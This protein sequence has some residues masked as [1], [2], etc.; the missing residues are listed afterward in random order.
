[1]IKEAVKR[2]CSLSNWE[3]KGLATAIFVNK[4][5]SCKSFR[6]KFPIE[7]GWLHKYI[8]SYKVMPHPIPFLL[9]VSNKNQFRYFHLHGVSVERRYFIKR[10]FKKSMQNFIER[11]MPDACLTPYCSDTSYNGVCKTLISCF[12]A[13]FT[14]SLAEVSLLSLC[15]YSLTLVMFL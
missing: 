2:C 5:G 3:S 12:T 8:K 6:Y 13:K 15:G 11:C 1:M 4:Y 10:K 9:Q 7:V 14:T